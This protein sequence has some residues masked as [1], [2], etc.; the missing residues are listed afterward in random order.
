MMLSSS[1]GQWVL[2]SSNLAL[3]SLHGDLLYSS[4]GAP[5]SAPFW[6]VPVAILTVSGYHFCGLR[7]KFYGAWWLCV[8]RWRCFSGFMVKKKLCST[9]LACLFIG[10]I[11]FSRKKPCLF[12]VDRSQSLPS[13]SYL[14]TLLWKKGDKDYF[15]QKLCVRVKDHKNSPHGK[16]HH[17]IYC[18]MSRVTHSEPGLPMVFTCILRMFLFLFLI[19]IIL[20]FLIAWRIFRNKNT[21]YGQSR[22]RIK[23]PNYAILSVGYLF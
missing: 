13:A 11:R 4:P 12:W 14:A 10:W 18:V 15:S 8:A 1:N 9:S 16:F 5:S 3:P 22:V 19:C 20:I 6:T 7:S 21:A 23:W 17:T 2:S